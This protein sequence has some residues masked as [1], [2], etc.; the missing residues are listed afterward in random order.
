MFGYIVPCKNQLGQEGFEAFGAYY[1]GLCKSM[2]R[3]CSQASRLGLSYD[4]SFLAMLL[5]AVTG[6]EHVEKEERCAAHPFKKRMCVKQDRSVD[7][8]ACVGVMLMYLKLL[9]DWRDERSIKALLGMALLYTGARRARKKYPSEYEFIRKCLDELSAMEAANDTDVDRAA[10]CFAKILQRLFAPDYITDKGTRRILDWFGYNIGRWIFVIDA[11]NDLEKDNE[12]GAYNPLLGGFDGG[13]IAEYRKA[14]A[15]QLE[16]SLTYTLGNAAA[17][18]DLLELRRGND[19][20]NA[21]IYDSLRLR[22]QAVLY[23]K[24]G[25]RDGSI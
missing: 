22:Q 1:C 12:S 17:A 18:F 21:I 19:A 24:T 3:Q 10:D 9:D 20:L 2:G 14:V 13:D 11:A 5:S 4:V 25:D 8:G 16:V 7:Y 15:K 6:D 23:K